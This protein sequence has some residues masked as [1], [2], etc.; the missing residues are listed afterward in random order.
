MLRN[1]VKM[2]SKASR[3]REF[4]F[5]DILLSIDKCFRDQDWRL[6]LMKVLIGRMV[7]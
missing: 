6:I 3:S 4:E 7:K 5:S 1:R 2:R